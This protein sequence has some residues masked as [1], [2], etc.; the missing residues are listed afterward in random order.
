MFFEQ[1]GPVKFGRLAQVRTSGKKN[2]KAIRCVKKE[3]T[4]CPDSV[5]M[6]IL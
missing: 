2:M 5:T 6:E 3:N 4:A 1:A